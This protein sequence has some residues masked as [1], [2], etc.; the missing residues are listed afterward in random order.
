VRLANGEWTG[1]SFFRCPDPGLA[2][3]VRSVATE[4]TER[5]P[6]F[7]EATVRY[8]LADGA[9]YAC[10]V[11][12]VKDDPFVRIGEAMDLGRIGS[13]AQWRLVV[14]VS[15]GWR[16]DGWR[17]DHVFWMTPEGRLQG[18]AEDFRA[19][20]GA[21]GLPVEKPW[22]RREFGSRALG[23][24]EEGESVLAW[25]V[26]YPWAPV[27]HYFG[28]SS[29]ADLRA[30][31][32]GEAEAPPF[33]GVVPMHA[34]RWRGAHRSW[35]TLQLV[36]RGDGDAALHLPLVAEPHPQ[37]LTHT[38][39]YD[40]EVPFTELRRQWALVAGPLQYHKTLYAFR[41]YQGYINLDDYE[42]WVLAWED[43]PQ[44]RYPRLVFTPEDV[45]RLRGRLT[46]L[47]GGE[48]LSRLLYF[49]G[50]EE[51]AAELW[52]RLQRDN[53][54]SG[55]RGQV[56][57]GIGR[58]GWRALSKWQSSFRQTQMASWTGPAEELLATEHLAEDDRA[59][60]K[61]WIAAACYMLSHPDFNP[62]GSMIHLGPINM[63][64]NR[65]GALPL[66]AALL[67][68]HPR[69]DEWL[70]VSE[71]ELEYLLSLVVAPRGAWGEVVTYYHAGASH[72]LQDASVL[73]TGGRLSEK[74]AD[75]ARLAS[76]YMLQ[77]MAPRDPRFGTRRV[78]TWGHEGHWINTHWLVAA[79]LMRERDP[80]LA[81]DFAWGWDQLGRPVEA[82]H[83]AGFS[84]RALLHAEL[85][86]ELPEGYVPPALQSAWLPGFGA[87][88]RAHAGAPTETYLSYRQGYCVSHSDANQGDFVL[89]ARGAPLSC[90]SLRTYA[91]HGDNEF[92]RANEE[93][94]WHNRVRFG[95]MSETGG[96][97][98]GGPLS[99]VHATAFDVEADYLRGVGE[100]GPQ[101][102]HRQILLLKSPQPAGPSY[103]VLRD[104]FVPVAGQQ[105][106]R[107][108]W[109]LRTPGAAANTVLDESGLVHTSPYADAVLEARFVQPARV[110]GR[111]REVSREGPMYNQ[112]AINWVQAGSPTLQKKQ[113]TNIR[114]RNTL[115]INAFGPI[116]GAQDILVA[117]YPR[118]GEEA[119]P[120]VESLAPG[121]ARI[122][123]PESVDTVFLHHR[124]IVYED[125]ELAWRGKAGA[126]R[127]FADRA[128]FIVAEGGGELTYRGTTLQ[129]GAPTVRAVPAGELGDGETFTH[130]PEL[131]RPA[132]EPDPED[133]PVAVLAPGVRRQEREAGPA[134]FFAFE[135]P[136]EFT[137]EEVVF[138]GRR[139]AI[140]IDRQADRIR[141]RM[142]EGAEGCRA[143]V[144]DVGAAFGPGPWEVVVHPDRVVGRHAGGN[145][146]LMVNP[147]AGLDRMPVLEIDGQTYAPGM[148]G[149]GLAV[150]LLAG[151]EDF[152]LRTIAQPPVFRTAE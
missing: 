69:H 144:G 24:P 70:T 86:E 31:A 17:P 136:G 51:R 112:A 36:T 150:P 88:L 125:D 4:I 93:F 8:E 151:E 119:S 33:V 117:L 104:S 11:R 52:G 15:P 123:T 142:A 85:L 26:W 127:V 44:T 34:G 118:G 23:Y 110:A 134:Y 90:L 19:A 71:A 145:R 77:L 140:L 46:E 59:S 18:V 41:R 72:M 53:V 1:G 122:T 66:A 98:G 108:W 100:Y 39:E 146:F 60:L 148:I 94:G 27:A 97:P 102:W 107:K 78:P 29:L 115:T 92:S 130:E 137:D 89:Y 57:A 109:Y 13:G 16:P 58:S 139:G 7:V 95:A 114:I 43:D 20:A 65:F 48:A 96:W 84:D 76:R 30:Q 135:E 133:G 116:D 50:G 143:A 73:E 74:T 82:H 55:P 63:P 35:R 126:L 138:R 12:L 56:L 147:P 54:W 80:A 152:V 5:G 81:R 149:E 83:D 121:V 22:N 105:R 103:F 32:A 101:R 120:Q 64:M 128:V 14:S 62:R 42:E 132:V 3:V 40:P 9:W 131:W 124:P 21:A 87:V 2:P 106:Q 25:S 91:I 141:L 37:R 113:P 6:L 75:L 67:P 79:S 10:T 49:G 129:A 61:A 47:P 28:L 99:N 45:E 68:D 111:A 38:G